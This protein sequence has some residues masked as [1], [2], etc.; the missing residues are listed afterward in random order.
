MTRTGFH[1]TSL[2][3]AEEAWK[4]LRNFIYLAGQTNNMAPYDGVYEKMLKVMDRI[5]SNVVTN[6]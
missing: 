1:F 6:D 2:G 5:E 4:T 3:E